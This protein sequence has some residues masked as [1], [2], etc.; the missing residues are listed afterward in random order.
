MNDLN[1]NAMSANASTS[2]NTGTKN[3]TPTSAGHASHSSSTPRTHSLRHRAFLARQSKQAKAN[4]KPVSHTEFLKKGC[5]TNETFTATMNLKAIARKAIRDYL[6]YVAAEIASGNRVR[7]YGV[8]TITATFRK[9]RKGVGEFRVDQPDCYTPKIKPNAGLKKQLVKLA[10]KKDKLYFGLTRKENSPGMKARERSTAS[11][12]TANQGFQEK[13]QV[14]SG[15]VGDHIHVQVGREDREA[16]RVAEG[17]KTQ[18]GADS[19]PA[20]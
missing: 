3:P 16:L 15:S 14:E 7:L 20:C 2:T 12:V 19:Q 17:F 18:E 8:G 13:P 1:Q 9:G 5:W 11:G 4:S 6:L 10:E